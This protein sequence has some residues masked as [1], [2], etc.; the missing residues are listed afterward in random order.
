MAGPVVA[1]DLGGTAMKGAIVREPGALDHVQTRPTGRDDG[2]DA[3][4]ERLAAFAAELAAAAGEPPIAAGV[5]VPGIV[6]EEKGVARS[7]VNV[8]W[9]DVPLRD[10]LEPRLGVPVAVGQHVRAAARGEGR[11]GA[12]RGHADWLLVTVGTG[13]GAAVVV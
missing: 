10:R 11:L 6:D 1:I 8:G 7:S 3:V 4:L 5:A 9:R 2:P 12:A 13:V